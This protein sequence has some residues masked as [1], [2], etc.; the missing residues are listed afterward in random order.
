M[1]FVGAVELAQ[2]SPVSVFARRTTSRNW[3]PAFTGSLPSQICSLP[4]IFGSGVT[5][6]FFTNDTGKDAP[7]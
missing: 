5:L 7:P 4:T 2:I 6:S 1:P 3:I